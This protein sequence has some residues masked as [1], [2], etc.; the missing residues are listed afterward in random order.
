MALIT[1][2]NIEQK[3]TWDQITC[4]ETIGTLH[5][6]SIKEGNYFFTLYLYD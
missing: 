4:S 6:L 3:R 5:A 1:S 2:R